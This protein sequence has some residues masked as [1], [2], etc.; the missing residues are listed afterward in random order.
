M[1]ARRVLGR[2]FTTR[3]T[4]RDDVYLGQHAQSLREEAVTGGH[5]TERKSFYGEK[6]SPQ[7]TGSERRL[8]TRSAD[9]EY[10]RRQASDRDSAAAHVP[11]TDTERDELHRDLA[12]SGW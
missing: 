1:A 11:M 7:M 6:D 9:D 12:A 3:Q 8:T 10:R 4:L 5:K 2:Q